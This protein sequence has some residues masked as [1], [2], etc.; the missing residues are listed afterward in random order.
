MA[1]RQSP[2]TARRNPQK[3]RKPPD[4]LAVVL[5]S[6]ARQESKEAA[7]VGCERKSKEARDVVTRMLREDAK[8]LAEL[9]RPDRLVEDIRELCRDA[10]LSVGLQNLDTRCSVDN[11]FVV[12]LRRFV[13][14][15]THLL[16]EFGPPPPELYRPPETRM[17][18]HRLVD[19]IAQ[20]AEPVA[21]RHLGDRLGFDDQT[22]MVTFDGSAIPVKDPDAY[23][24]YK[25]IAGRGGAVVT[26]K[27][28]N[29]IPGLRGKR[30][31]RLL[32]RL[33]SALRDTIQ[34]RPG[35]G[36]W[37]HVPPRK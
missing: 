13:A 27:E 12:E 16:R 6:H 14:E 31:D 3:T 28:L 18:V 8:R 19:A 34:T 11:Q 7:R 37:L 23:T 30:N 2:A 25:A 1:A 10:R 36:K 26:E 24:L 29:D 33:P 9:N 22:H 32:D 4:A 5:A 15:K 21:D 35:R 20:W 17:D